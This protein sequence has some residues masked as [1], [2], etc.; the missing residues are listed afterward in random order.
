MTSSLEQ[1]FE[2]ALELH[3]TD[4][5]VYLLL[6]FSVAE[7]YGAK[8]PFAIIGTI[9]GFPIRLSLTPADAGQH[10]LRVPKEVRRAIDKNWPEIVHVVL[11][12]DTEETLELPKPLAQALRS[13]GLQAQFNELPYPERKEL[14]QWVGRAK[15][16]DARRQRIQ[17][18]L[19]RFD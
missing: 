6:P 14:S 16:A 11:R 1:S 18:I 7:V 19:D 5:G 3:D 10:E 9:D 17:E 13:T 4:G 12:P 2:A 15:S 8:G